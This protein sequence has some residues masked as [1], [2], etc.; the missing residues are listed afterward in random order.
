M[1]L[2]DELLEQLN[3]PKLSN[4]QKA[5]I[6]CR[7]AAEA[8]HTGQYETAQ[9][10]LGE[11][12]RGIRERPRLKGLTELAQAEV[13]LQCGA[14]TGWLGSNRQIKDA[15]EAA[16]DLLSE[17]RRIFTKRRLPIK[18]AETQYELGMCYWRLGAFD[19]GRIVLQ[20]AL[21]KLDITN[22][23]LKAKILIRS[24]II[25]NSAGRYYEALRILN[26]A[27]P[28][29]D[30]A[31]NAIKGK[32]HA[33]KAIVLRRLGSPEHLDQAIIEY[34]AAIH[35]LELAKHE[36]YCANNLNNLAFLLGKLGRYAE[37]HENLD[38]AY[39][40]FSRLNDTG[41]IAQ[42]N[43]TRARTLLGEGRNDEALRMIK[44]AVATLERGGEYALLADAMVVQATVLARL[45]DHDR[46][47]SLFRQAINT[48]ED[49]GARTNAGLAAIIMIEEQHARMPPTELLMI[50][51]RADNLLK[52]T[53]DTEA[54]ARLRG[55]ARFVMQAQAAPTLSAPN[56]SLTKV[57][58]AYEHRFIKQALEDA[59]GSVS[60][61]AKLLG[62]GHQ[63]LGYII[64][65]RH[66][67][68]LSKRTP[69]IHRKRSFIKLK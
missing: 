26:E 69:I 50:Y 36:R 34:T 27:A 10:Y 61:A 47:L 67:D 68:L 35:Y 18:V 40:I 6:R 51:S 4:D 58:R 42:V 9:A 56:F 66:R 63:S 57:V 2:A 20:D 54:I 60:H 22:V 41:N 53:Q 32:W 28:V 29:F 43:E 62:I 55:C 37:A 48:A 39:A 31:N 19:E 25:E 5:L 30:I 7:L 21:S 45:E 59:Q 15:Q 8:I 24:T 65:T 52:Q 14:L 38:R 3:N 13:L 11:R 49:A 1:T 23:E 16:K 46:S 33:Q 12:W 64:N 17:A 44:S